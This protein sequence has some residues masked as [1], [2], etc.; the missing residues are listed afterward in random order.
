MELRSRAEIEAGYDQV[1]AGRHPEGDSLWHPEVEEG[2]D[3]LRRATQDAVFEFA[4]GNPVPRNT[5]YG[6]EPFVA[7]VK[8]C[9]V[10]LGVDMVMFSD[11]SLE[12]QM[13]DDPAHRDF[14]VLTLCSWYQHL[15]GA[16]PRSTA[17][18][19]DVLR[20]KYERYAATVECLKANGFAMAD[21]PSLESFLASE[22]YQ[23]YSEYG[24]RGAM[25]FPGI[26]LG[27]ASEAEMEALASEHPAEAELIRAMWTCPIAAP[28]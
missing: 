7:W 1:F 17:S 22:D 20:D 28:E 6:S 4:A 24:V 5:F 25:G 15:S 11:G 16:T 3:E 12:F 9:S 2:M 14:L 13:S 18:D 10:A 27:T 23:P 26:D 21:M 8:E 19:D